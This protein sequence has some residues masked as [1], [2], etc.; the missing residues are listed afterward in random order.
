MDEVSLQV[1]E[2]KSDWIKL[3]N[4]KARLGVWSGGIETECNFRERW[5]DLVCYEQ[6]E[7]MNKI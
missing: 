3:Q 7:W 4:E 6:V 5:S 1:V 2:K